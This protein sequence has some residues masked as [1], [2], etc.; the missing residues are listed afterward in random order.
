[1]KKMGL[2]CL[3]DGKNQVYFQSCGY[4]N[5]KHGTFYFF[6]WRKQTI[7]HSWGKKFKYNREVFLSKQVN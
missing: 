4:E 3:K 2:K 7:S 1:M 5:V 6:C